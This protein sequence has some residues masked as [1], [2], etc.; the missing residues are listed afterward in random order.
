MLCRLENH[1][2]MVKK[3]HFL[4]HLEMFH[5]P[6]KHAGAFINPNSAHTDTLKAYGVIKVTNLLYSDAVFN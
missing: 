4:C 5:K 6:L 2:V 1:Q 3:T